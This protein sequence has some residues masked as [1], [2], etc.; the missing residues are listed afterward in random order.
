MFR[1]R[2]VSTGRRARRRSTAQRDNSSEFRGQLR[3]ESTGWALPPQTATEASPWTSFVEMAERA[4]ES[5]VWGSPAAI[6][7]A[8]PRVLGDH[9]AVSTRSR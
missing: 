3:L 1:S 7:F 6:T 5:F 4:W 9:D 8:Q 2:L